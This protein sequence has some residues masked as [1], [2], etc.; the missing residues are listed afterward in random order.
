MAKRVVHNPQVNRDLAIGIF[1]ADAALAAALTSWPGINPVVSWGAVLVC[2]FGAAIYRRRVLHEASWSRH[3]V[4]WLVI[5][6]IVWVGIQAAFWNR[7]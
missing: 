4:E 6:A 7:S 2:G 1:L 3:E 5:F